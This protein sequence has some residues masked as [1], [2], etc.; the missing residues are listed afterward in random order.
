[1]VKQSRVYLSP[2]LCLLLLMTFFSTMISICSFLAPFQVL[3]LQVE[4]MEVS[5]V[6][7]EF[8]MVV[9]SISMSF[10]TLVCVISSCVLWFSLSY[11][12][13]ETFKSRFEWLVLGFVVS[14]ILLIF[15]PNFLALL[16]GWDALGIISFL[17]VVYY[18]SPNVLTAGMLTAMVNRLGDVMLM[19]SL[20]L[21]TAL[22]SWNLMFLTPVG[23]PVW[24]VMFA[25]LAAMTKSAQFPFSSWLPAAM[26]A[27]TPVSALVHS[28][29]LVTAGVYILIRFYSTFTLC[30][31]FNTAC[32]V[33]GTVTL[34]L[35]GIAANLEHDLKKVIALSTLSQLGVM[36]LALSSG[37][38]NLALYH[39][40]TH[41]LFKALLFICAGSIIHTNGGVQDIRHLGNIWSQ[42]PV[43]V[44]CFNLANLCLCGAP[45]LSGYY[46]KDLILE[47]MLSLPMNFFMMIFIFFATGMTSG[48]ALRLSLSTILGWKNSSPMYLNVDSSPQLTNP[49]IVLACVAIVGGV[50]FQD[51][52]LLA[53]FDFLLPV[54]YKL[55]TTCV[56]FL[57]GWFS[58][59]LWKC[60][61]EKTPNMTMSKYYLSSMWFLQFLSTQS[62]VKGVMRNT[63]N[64]FKSLDYGWVGKIPSGSITLFTQSLTSQNQKTQAKYINTYVML[65]FA[66]SF[67]LMMFYWLVT[68]IIF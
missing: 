17:L 8:C 36:M 49:M 18:Q 66:A 16:L 68:Y 31:W 40:Y 58:L 34:L 55:L 64:M 60:E 38:Y 22:G 56:V 48:Y 61:P 24:V 26:A 9:D 28:S 43:T 67:S 20:V 41:A 2:K 10:S 3:Y 6:S 46:S 11:M 52:L 32:L 37:L 44:T 65:M 47:T 19:M 63:L 21:L 14:M 4:L 45:F 33:I 7:L 53:P 35:A 5:G 23:E 13:S 29:T 57:G 27:P 1:M 59:L 51:L 15:I 50:L 25:L 39:L 42:M 62:F 30:Y 12:H 54:P